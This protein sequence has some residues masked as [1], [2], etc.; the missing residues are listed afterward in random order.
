MRN[1]FSSSVLSCKYNL[2]ISFCTCVILSLLIYY[3]GC[4]ITQVL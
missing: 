2:I 4:I 3:F 1:S